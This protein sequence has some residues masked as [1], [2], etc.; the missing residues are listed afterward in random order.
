MGK[1]S[2][3]RLIYQTLQDHRLKVRIRQPGD[4]PARKRSVRLLGLE[5]LE[6]RCLPSTLQPISLPPG[7]QL[8]SDT[9]AGASISPSVSAD[10]RYVAFQSNALNLVPNQTGGAGNMFLLD[11]ASGRIALISPSLVRLRPRRPRRERESP[12]HWLFRL[13]AG[14]AGTSFTIPK[15]STKFWAYGGVCR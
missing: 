9:A 1:S 8:P 12:A 4:I 6:A 10:G 5:P 11:R 15:T 7:N 3:S 2:K 14:M 13:L